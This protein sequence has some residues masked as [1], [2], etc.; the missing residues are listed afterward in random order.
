MRS[1]REVNEAIERYADTVQRIC[2]LHLKN[3]SDTQDLFQTVF[4][5]YALSSKRFESDAHEKAWIIRVTINACRDLIRSVFRRR[6]V[7]L[8][9]VLNQPAPVPEEHR[10]L[11]Q[12]VLEL[13]VRYREVIYLHYYEGYTA[14]E[15]G[16]ILG[17]SENTV[18]A[19][20]SRGRQLLKLALGGEDR[21]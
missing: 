20:M 1:E 8:E 14:A 10:E 6:T 18:Y 9:A 5:K 15:T 16:R 12:A 4:W 3:P 17:R 7:S 21:E 13:P 2:M 19:Q 11:L